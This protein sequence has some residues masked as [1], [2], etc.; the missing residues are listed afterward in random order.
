MALLE[1][2]R[3]SDLNAELEAALQRRADDG[4]LD[5]KCHVEVTGATRPADFKR[6]LLNVFK[7]D[8]AGKVTDVPLA[9]VRSFDELYRRLKLG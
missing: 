5:I 4:V 7:Q 8:E 2:T 3:T 1:M 9:S 6:A